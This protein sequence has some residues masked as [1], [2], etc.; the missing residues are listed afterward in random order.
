MGTSD[1]E[2]PLSIPQKNTQTEFADLKRMENILLNIFILENNFLTRAGLGG[3]SSGEISGTIF[4]FF[5]GLHLQ[6]K[7]LSLEDGICASPKCQAE[8]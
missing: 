2:H 6:W 1:A 3:N 8:S 7:T 4:F 5:I